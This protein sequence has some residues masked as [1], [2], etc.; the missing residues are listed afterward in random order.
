MYYNN[1]KSNMVPSAKFAWTKQNFCDTSEIK[2]GQAFYDMHNHL[3][4]EK[5]V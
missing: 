4:L 2:V 5:N 1:N 3:K